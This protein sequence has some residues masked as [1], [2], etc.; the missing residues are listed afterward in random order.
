MVKSMTGYGRA[1]ETVNGVVK[2]EA[3]AA[4][5]TPES[6]T[7]EVNAPSAACVMA[8]LPTDDVSP[9]AVFERALPPL[10]AMP[11][12]KDKPVSPLA[13]CPPQPS[14]PVDRVPKRQVLSRLTW[15]LLVATAAAGWLTAGWLLP[16]RVAVLDVDRVK[17]AVIARAKTQSLEATYRALDAFDGVLAAAVAELLRDERLV[18]LNAATVIGL[19]APTSDVTADVTDRVIRRLN[20]P[21][22][23]PTLGATP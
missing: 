2:R 15:W 3:L 20:A 1:V 7:T 22:A 11:E 9:E 8:A 12:K 14:A 13:L 17:T 23:P 16:P 5:L 19:S 6:S 4:R 18:L 10:E 21:E